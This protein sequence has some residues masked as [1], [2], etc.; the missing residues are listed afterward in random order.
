MR[1]A[2]ANELKARGFELVTGG[3]EN[4][5]VRQPPRHYGGTQRTLPRFRA[6]H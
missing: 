2:F 5:L 6:A 1:Q 3:T 4:H